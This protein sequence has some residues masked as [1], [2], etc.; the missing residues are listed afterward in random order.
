MKKK[1]R[2]RREIQVIPKI[3]LKSEGAMRKFIKNVRAQKYPDDY[4]I[5]LPEYVED[6]HWS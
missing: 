5:T 2:S 3:N 6:S 4:T 1:K